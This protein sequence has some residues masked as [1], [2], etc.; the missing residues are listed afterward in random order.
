M[1]KLIA[2][3]CTYCGKGQLRILPLKQKSTICV[4]CGKSMKIISAR[5]LWAS[6][7]IYDL[8]DLYVK[9]SKTYIT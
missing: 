6:D 4:N 3:K 7:N 5:V 8:R 9:H 2:F 1:N